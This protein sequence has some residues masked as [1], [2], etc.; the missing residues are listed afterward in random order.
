MSELIAQ[1]CKLYV[2]AYD[3]SSS[4]NSLSME[5][6]VEVKDATAF[7]DDT[8]VKAPGLLTAMA[9]Y[10]GFFEAGVDAVDTVLY[11]SVGVTDT[12][13]TMCP[14]TGADGEVSYSLQGVTGTYNPLN[15]GTVGEMLKFSAA[16]ESSGGQ[17][18]QGTVMKRGT[19]AASGD[20]TGYQLG[21]VA[22]GEYV[23]GILHVTA[24]SG[25]STPTITVI[26][27]SDDNGSFTSATTR[28]SFTAATGVTSEFLAAVAGP[29]TD[30][31]WRASYTISGTDPSMDVIVLC[32]IK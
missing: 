1:D 16:F 19:V 17:L 7:G 11:G 14:T 6:S 10:E 20:G 13:M 21:A 23:Y 22:S 26:I 15:S 29:I 31:Y 2:G 32:G 25:T 18:V 4:A 24:L 9:N 3:L 28:L 27:E 12:I 5:Y 30:D 8:R